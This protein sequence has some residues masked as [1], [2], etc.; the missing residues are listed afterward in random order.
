[1][2][3]LRPDALGAE[4]ASQGVRWAAS[5][6]TQAV[7]LGRAVGDF[8]LFWIWARHMLGDP[9]ARGRAVDATL[10]L[11]LVMV[12]AVGAQ[13]LTR[14]ALRRPLA[15]L[16]LWAPEGS[17][18]PD[19]PLPVA[20]G[21]E[22]A[23]ASA[24]VP[25]EV[26]AQAAAQAA[27]AQAAAEAASDATRAEAGLVPPPERPVV[28]DADHPLAAAR[29][30]GEAGHAAAVLPAAG[31]AG[32]TLGDAAAAV[33]PAA[34]EAEAARLQRRQEKRHHT[35]RA[36]RRL[37]FGLMRLVLELIPV[38]VFLL[39]A[40]L[41]LA[42]RPGAA[43]LTRDVVVV[44]VQ[45]W[46]VLCAAMC[47]AHALFSPRRPRL[48]LLH[49]DDGAAAY[50]VR[51]LRRLLALAVFGN[52]ALEVGLLF[53]LYREAHDALLKLVALAAHGMLVVVVL[54]CRG[55]VAARLRA[56]HRLRD[57][58]GAPRG[59]W[60]RLRD[61]F[62]SVWH[63]VAIFFIVATWV[64]WAAELRDGFARLLHFV[65]VTLAVG[66]V[67]RLLGIL[68]L[69]GLDR[70]VR[71]APETATRFP[72]LEARTQR[73]YPAVRALLVA[74]LLAL[75]AV[76][77]LEVWG[78]EAVEWLAGSQ[79]GPRVVSALLTVLVSAAVAVGVWEGVNTAAERQ[80]DRLGRDAQVVRAA[81]LRTL[82]PILRTA[83]F[84]ALAVVL[85]LTVLSE[86][87]VNVAPLLA[88]AG[89]I[90]VA[91]GFGSQKL[92]QDFITGIFLLLENAMQVGDTVTLGGL[93]GVVETLSIRTIRLR[94]GDGS[95]HII[96][97]SSVTTV[98]NASRDFANA[99]VSVGVAYRED[100]D[101]VSRVLADIVAGMRADPDFSGRILGDLNLWGV[102][103]LG[104]FAVTIKG[105]IRTTSGGRW[106]VQ[107]EFNRRLKRRFEEEGIDI[108][109]PVRTLLTPDL[110]PAPGAAAPAVVGGPNGAMAA[111]GP[112]GAEAARA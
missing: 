87:G 102:D 101:R 94:A 103:Q 6:S 90:G 106:P 86:V 80:L 22:P 32:T 49:L 5:L 104:D 61:R 77:L 111:G 39:A 3:P 81:R 63:W 60:A 35:L 27:A 65:V 25:P 10:A 18:E 31:V 109:F 58:A 43:E 92:V 30:P 75:T 69:G 99:D 93:S 84:V 20:P 15:G 41:M 14:R 78:L 100:T 55:A 72:G 76:A 57:A 66:I 74:L 16:E 67:A 40:N 53:G 89:I 13:W 85:G 88:G 12:V 105:Q 96:P 71:V 23:A 50:L 62:A 70:L 46:A 24:Q 83:L 38:G 47:V 33:S 28:L 79:L 21:A 19:E 98:S 110:R 91:I 52:A 29:E 36:L 48:R 51:W 4:L 73:Y 64:V 45:A 8:P 7:S 54:Q 2:V 95:V 97:F 1:M 56:P 107:R 26:A 34:A 68:A 112:A 59:A 37:P 108:P 17:G 11:A 42:A 9:D 44:N 82:L